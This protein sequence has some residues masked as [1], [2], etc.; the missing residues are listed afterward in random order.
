VARNTH[1]DDEQRS[2]VVEHDSLSKAIGK[3]G[4]NAKL[5]A[6]LTGWKID[7]T[8]QEDEAELQRLETISLQYLNDFLNQIEGL[9]EFSREALARSNDFSTVE[10]LAE[11]EPSQ[12]LAFTGEDVEL[13]E[14]IIE[15]AKEYLERSE[16]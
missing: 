4:Q 12:L 7:V 3:R 8:E 2:D 16:E 1:D 9:S 14:E 11:A 15:G 10:R 5:A 13:A 6:K